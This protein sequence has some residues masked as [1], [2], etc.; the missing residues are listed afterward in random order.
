MSK[1]FK[2]I[3]LAIFFL[4]SFYSSSDSGETPEEEEEEGTASAYQ[5]SRAW[6]RYL[7][8]ETA[9]I[10]QTYSNLNSTARDMGL[11]TID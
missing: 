8:N 3:A 4:I 11:G 9:R 10:N 1:V 7:E 5:D 2:F 6:D